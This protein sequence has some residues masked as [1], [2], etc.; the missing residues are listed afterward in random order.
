M[1]LFAEEGIRS[2][3]FAL[4][5]VCARPDDL[6]AR[7]TAQYGAWLCGTVLA[8]VGMALHHKLC[9]TLGGSFNLP[10]AETH[11]V[12]LPYSM[13]FN[14]PSTP[15]AASRLCRALDTHDPAASLFELGRQL[16]VPVSLAALGLASEDLDRAA[17]I[18]MLSPYFNPR[19]LSY[20]GI[21][22]LLQLAF[23]GTRPDQSSFEGF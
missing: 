5:S 8:N 7:E 20:V 19:P 11:A 22:R 4:P 3:A 16:G 1:S 14:L 18:A 10:H 13:A 15:D 12:I 6:A 9:H 17:E 23:D 21:R 2:L